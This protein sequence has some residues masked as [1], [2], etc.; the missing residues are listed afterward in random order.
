LEAATPGRTLP[1]KQEIF[2]FQRTWI[3]RAGAAGLLGAFFVVVSFVLQRVGLNLP[4][5]N[6]NAD[7]F[8]FVHHHSTRIIYSSVLQGLGLALFVGPLVF[9]FKSGV[10]R[11]VRMRNSF[12]GLVAIGPLF[13]GLGVAITAVG[14]SQAAKDF[15]RQEPAIVQHARQQAAAPPAPVPEKKKGAAK[16]ATTTQATTT[17]ATTT[18][19]TV[20]A[21][22][23]SGG[24]T[25]IT[26]GPG[27]HLTPDQSAAVARENLADHL[28]RHTTVLIIGGLIQTIGVLGVMFG[29]IY[30]NL[31]GMRTGLET[32][33]WGAI[34]MAAG[35]GLILLGPLGIAVFVLWFAITGL[36]FL[37]VWPRGLPPAWEVGEAIPWQRPGEDAGGPGGAPPG[38]VEG[39]GREVSERPLAEDGAGGEPPAAQPGETAGQRRKKRKKRR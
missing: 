4:S 2:S 19:E 11:A 15:T 21:T 13:F 17:A 36:M 8:L 30:T 10:F 23:P 38:T 32:R 31:W 25:T 34:G 20:T 37:G 22:T 5:G 24:T 28:N 12:V 35:I 6:S 7:E 27:K 39:S 26:T 18:V 29:M 14:S 9:L 16:P 1:D 33:F 3:R